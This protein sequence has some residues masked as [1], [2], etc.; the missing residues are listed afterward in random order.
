MAKTKGAD[1]NDYEHFFQLMQPF[2]QRGCSMH[3]SALQCELSYSSLKEKCKRDPKYLARIEKA[4]E[5]PIVLARKAW[6]KKIEEWD[7]IASRD[8]LRAKRKAEFSERV[9]QT[10]ADGESLNKDIVIKLPSAE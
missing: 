3:E 6:M 2:L 4:Q 5:V 7:Y 1:S 9:E 10:W 8:Y